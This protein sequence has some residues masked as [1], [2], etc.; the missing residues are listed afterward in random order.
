MN[1]RRPS[2]LLLAAVLG[3]LALPAFADDAATAAAAMQAI[4]QTAPGGAPPSGTM[5]EKKKN[6]HG[7]TDL[8][9]PVIEKK[10]GGEKKSS[11]KKS[12]SKPT[13][14]KYKST[15]L[16]GSSEHNYRFNENAEPIDVSKKKTAAK[17]K[18]ASSE[19]S[20]E[21]SKDEKPAACADEEPCPARSSDAD[22]L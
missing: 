4:G 5:A 19:E 14:S 10:A 12:K 3:V 11:A 8:H 17:K 18:K 6:D 15:E 2:A 7:F 9:A 20:A 21:E 22:A 16:A 13:V 1:P